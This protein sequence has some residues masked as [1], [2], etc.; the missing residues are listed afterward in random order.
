MSKIL[1]YFV[2]CMAFVTYFATCAGCMYMRGAN[3][4]PTFTRTVEQQNEAA[5]IVRVDCD[6]SRS[7]GSGV[8]ISATRVLTANHLFRRCDNPQ[9]KI[10]ESRTG[11]RYTATVV[12][13]NTKADLAEL[14][15]LGP[16]VFSLVSIG[17]V[18]LGDTVCLVTKAPD[19]ARRCGY[20][21]KRDKLPGD[22]VHSAVTEP[23]NSGAGLYS[24]RGELVGI[25][26]H[27]R[28][29]QNGQYCGGA[30][31]SLHGRFPL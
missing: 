25:V 9:I 10:S 5:V 18:Q 6:G 7:F 14:R 11:T 4:A 21:A 19:F 17:Q 2:V 16:M 3:K 26:T 20:A 1:A 22:V 13:R 30:M 8:K 31:T 29:C 12:A 28:R 15:V 24:L 27:F 23:G